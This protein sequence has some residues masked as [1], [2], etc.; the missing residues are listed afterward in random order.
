MTLAIIQARLTSKRL[1]EKIYKTI[2]NIRIIDRV[3]SQVEISKSI[4]RLVVAT[5]HKLDIDTQQFIGS[6]EDVLDR[7][8]KCACKFKPDTIV[9]ITAD[10]PLLDVEVIDY[11]VKYYRNHSY[12]YV[13]IAPVDG[14]DVEVFSMDI[15][16]E[17]WENT[18]D[19][20]D[21]EHVTPYMR[22]KTKLSVDTEGDLK[23]V[24]G[25]YE[26]GR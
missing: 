22:R 20:D 15:L 17:A 23:H 5:P 19:K 1:P 9:R 24:R 8:Y 3:I 12:P 11:A 2:D 21:R 4:D 25:M 26:L 7:F 10:C 6:E 13:V 14:L 18:S 16:K